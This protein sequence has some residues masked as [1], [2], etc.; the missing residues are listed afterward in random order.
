MNSIH[1]LGL[2]IAAVAA[3]LTVAGALA[4]AGRIGAQVA[5][6]EAT[7]IPGTAAS[8]PETTAT[9][10]LQPLTIYVRP[11]A[12]PG[13]VTITGTAAPGGQTGTQASPQATPQVVR[14][15]V[16]GRDRGH[17]GSGDGN[18]GSDG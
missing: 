18:G 2:A 8:A 15:V 12:T 11:A 1:R 6:S 7:P 13:I 17:E 16:P 10:T 9:P 14:V 3:A 5:T 4:V